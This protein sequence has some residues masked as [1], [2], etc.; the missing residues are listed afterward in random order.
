MNKTRL[1]IIWLAIAGSVL[2]GCG[3]ENST[4]PA[5]TSP[6]ITAP[7]A[8]SSPKDTV[9]PA[10]GKPST[11]PATDPNSQAAGTGASSGNQAGSNAST[12]SGSTGKGSGSEPAPTPVTAPP[13]GAAIQ[14]VAKPE[15]IAALV[16]KQNALPASYEPQ[17]LVYPNVA[18]TFS[19]KLDKRKMRK[20]A[21]TALEALFEG[22]K[23]DGI[24]LAGV[25]AYR[26]YATQ[27]T[28]YNNY[29]KQD[30]EEK[31]RTYSAMP[32]HSEHETGLSIDV[33][34]SNGKCAAQNCFAATKE[35]AWLD[36]HAS[37]YGFIIRY[38]KGKEAITGYQ[39]EPWHLRYLG[40]QLSK[41]ITE[42]GVTLEE[43][44]NAVPVNK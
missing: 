5:A 9:P 38:P 1:A 13:K 43:Y 18:F 31:A 23:K 29:V 10:Q 33:S 21:A 7:A 30:G 39:Y 24:S 20:E 22:A 14:V 17:D 2:G 40:T 41:E 4:P 26:S 25:S 32:G 6:A 37:E 12:N 11:T 19:E 3:N 8:S 34:G 42:K 35:S 28:L 44:F 16:N 27:K 36:A 15:S